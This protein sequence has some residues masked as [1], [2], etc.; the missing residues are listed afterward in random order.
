MSTF[1][2]TPGPLA[3]E[4]TPSTT[5]PAAPDVVVEPALQRYRG[6]IRGIDLARGLAI[7]GMIWAHVRPGIDVTATFTNF[8]G[9]IPAG[10]SSALFALL[11]GISLAILSGRNVPY[12]DLQLRHAQLRIAGRAVALLAFAAFLSLFPT[13]IAVIL[14][15]YA[16]WF[17]L[18]LPLL[19]WSSKKLAIAAGVVALVGPQVMHLANLISY[20]FDVYPASGPN[21]YLYDVLVTGHYPGLA[22]MAYVIAGIAIGRT[23]LSASSAR[24]RLLGGGLML[25][26]LGYGTAYLA[27]HTFATETGFES[28]NSMEFVPSFMPLTLWDVF[29]AEPHM[30]TTTEVIGNLGFGLIV[31]A[32]CLWLSPLAKHLLFPIAAVGSMSLTAYVGHAFGLH[33]NEELFFSS[34]ATPF[35]L[36]AGI[37]VLFCTVWALLPFR[38]GPLEWMTYW[39]SQWFAHPA[40]PRPAVQPVTSQAG[41]LPPTPQSPATSKPAAQP[42]LEAPAVPEPN[43]Q[44]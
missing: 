8:L 1:T 5:T 28:G 40:L 39:F 25:A 36:V 37:A 31:L 11:A 6:R 24:I 9:N 35:L 20:T 14:G 21:S 38:R 27:T 13:I 19:S 26:V 4:S 33:F 2:T 23:D 18:A 43:E 29:T 7:L 10:R 44:P 42:E 17:L 16:A 15:Y 32:V 41:T 22:Y 3:P 12:T 34:T 30:N